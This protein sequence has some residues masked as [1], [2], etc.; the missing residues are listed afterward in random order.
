MKKITLLISFLILIKNHAFSKNIYRYEDILSNYSY[1]DKWNSF[2]IFIDEDK[3]L[4]D[5][6]DDSFLSAYFKNK[7][8][9]FIG[10]SNVIIINNKKFNISS[11]PGIGKYRK[12]NIDWR[13]VFIY[14][15]KKSV[16]I[17]T[18]FRGAN[19]TVQRYAQIIFIE[20]YLKPNPYYFSGLFLDCS[21][22]RKIENKFYLPSY[23]IFGS[24][25]N[26][27]AETVKFNYRQISP[28]FPIKYKYEGKFPDIFNVYE[29]ELTK[30]QVVE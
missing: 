10:N 3:Y 30:S 18:T 1:F 19:S 23:E 14:K 7:N 12:D 29:F 15:N 22:M 28:R 17:Q 13:R 4:K 27:D 6:D 21:Y 2:D 9:E 24:K 8:L 20:N 16:C 5:P 11:L 25:Y 26:H